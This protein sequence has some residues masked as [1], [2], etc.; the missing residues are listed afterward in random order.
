M[1]YKFI[2]SET[3]LKSFPYKIDLHGAPPDQLLYNIYCW[4]NK[5]NIKYEFA[6]GDCNRWYFKDEQD[7]LA[8]KLKWG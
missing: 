6:V 1:K 3:M 2:S 7:V 4:L 5:E 8:F